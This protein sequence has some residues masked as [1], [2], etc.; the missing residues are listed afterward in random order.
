[1]LRKE[2]EW[3]PFTPRRQTRFTSATLALAVS[4]GMAIGATLLVG[5]SRQVLLNTTPS[6]PIG[7][8]T[9]TRLQPKSGRL[10]AFPAPPAAF[11]YADLRLSY[12]R[13]E[14][15]LKM[16]AAGPGDRVCTLSRRVVIN[17]ALHGAIAETD[18]QGRELPH[19]RGCRMLATGELFALS[20]RVPNSFDSR[21]FGPVSAGSVVGVFRPLVLFKDVR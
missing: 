9:R 12:L 16:I 6:E 14:P 10:A 15:M 8:Y 20:D 21:Y 4:G 7:L 17:G 11:P 19:W 1:M 13:R 5:S 2:L 18:R 3:G